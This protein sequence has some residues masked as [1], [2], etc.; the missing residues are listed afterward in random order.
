MSHDLV[1]YREVRRGGRGNV[2]FR[3]GCRDGLHERRLGRLWDAEILGRAAVA[4]VT[5]G[6]IL[7]LVNPLL[8]FAIFGTLGFGIGLALF[9]I[10][11][12]RHQM[13]A[14]VDRLLAALAE[15]GSLTWN[16]ETVLAFL[17]AGVG[18]VLVALSLRLDSGESAHRSAT[19]G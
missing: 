19:I 13:A 16:T 4:L 9:A 3:R 6:A 1:R 15:L 12:W 14:K 18:L 8:Q 17:L 7:F 2:V 5:S 10:V 11:L